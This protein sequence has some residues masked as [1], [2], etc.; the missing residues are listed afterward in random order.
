VLAGSRP[1]NHPQRRVGALAAL[2][3][4]WRT[5]KSALEK[6]ARS[7]HRELSS[8]SHPYWNHHYTLTSPRSARSLAVLGGSRVREI[9]A[10]VAFPY[11]S[12]RRDDWWAGYA[13]LAAAL[14]NAK[15]RRAALRLLGP[16]PDAAEFTRSLCQQQALIQ[17]YEDFCLRD[18]S[19]CQLCLFPEQL[20]RWTPEEA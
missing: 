10:N 8:L 15:S 1:L 3:K 19:D 17:I 7:F 14:D 12:L 2:A 6:S 5:V 13:A 16:R 20:A 9:L 18:H 11:W 4:H